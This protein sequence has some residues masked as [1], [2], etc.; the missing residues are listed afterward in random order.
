M[1]NFYFFF[2]S[3]SD[4]A[5]FFTWYLNHYAFDDICLYMIESLY[6]VSAKVSLVHFNDR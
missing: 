2:D 5:S 3:F 1:Q 6:L 4:I